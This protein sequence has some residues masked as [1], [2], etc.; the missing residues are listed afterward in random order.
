M[1]ARKYLIEENDQRRQKW[2]YLT[3][4]LDQMKRLQVEVLLDNLQRVTF[5]GRSLDEAS[6]LA[7]VGAFATFAFPMVRRIFP[8]LIAQSLCSVQPMTQPTGKVFFLDF[9]YGTAKGD[10]AVDDRLDQKGSLAK[11]YADRTPETGDVAEVNFD[12]SS[13]TVDAEEKALKA[14]WTIEAQQDL[15]AYHGLDAESELM[16][17]LSDEIIREVDMII[18]DDMVANATAGNVNWNINMPAEAPWTNID[19]KIY[20]ATL[21]DAIVDANNLVFKKRYRNCTWIVA[22]SDTCTRMEKLEGFKLTETVDDAVFNIGIHQFGVLRNRFV[23]YKHPWFQTDKM[24]LGFKGA[25]WL[26]TGYVYAPYIPLYT[27]PLIVHPDTLKPI[28]GMMSR[29]GRKMVNGDCFATVT[30]VSS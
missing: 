18:I 20:K 1:N 4:G 12:I 9:K 21:Y 3:E 8:K 15:K 22:D 26:D 6:A 30:L 10:I 27:T 29:Y 14:Q 11:N 25:S 16:V 5:K 2:A 13:V 17:V 7:N 19:P 23:V 24:L 28:R